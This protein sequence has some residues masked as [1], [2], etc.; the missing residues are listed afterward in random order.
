VDAHPSRRMSLAC[1]YCRT[2]N[3][4][5]WRTLRVGPNEI[6]PNGGIALT[7]N[8]KMSRVLRLVWVLVVNGIIVRMAFTS[9]FGDP[10]NRATLNRNNL[11]EF[12]LKAA[13]PTV[14]V[15]LDFAQVRFAKW[16]NVGYLAALG[17]Y[18]FEEAIRWWSDPFHGVL[19]LLGF[20]LLIAATLTGVVYRVTDNLR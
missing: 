7:R 19:L 10:L 14:G 4:G 1:R 13:I 9:I 8:E 17:F 16:V 11:L 6:S 15:A 18:Y 12:F 5:G 3:R 20:G 2:P